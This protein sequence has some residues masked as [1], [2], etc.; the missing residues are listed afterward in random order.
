MFEHETRW[1]TSPSPEDWKEPYI[2]A[3]T[4]RACTGKESEAYLRTLFPFSAR[5]L[6]HTI[7]GRSKGAILKWARTRLDASQYPIQ[8]L[9]N[10]AQGGGLVTSY[11]SSEVE[12]IPAVSE[13]V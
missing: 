12:L 9:V 3:T 11:D 8:T 7:N 4:L 13:G 2:L 1:Q 5:V 10:S 6:K